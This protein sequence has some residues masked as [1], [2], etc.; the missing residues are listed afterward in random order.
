LTALALSAANNHAECVRL[1]LDAGANVN[2][3]MGE[4]STALM[5]AAAAAGDN[6]D[7]VKMLLA[8]GA[9]SSV[10]NVD[11]LTALDVAASTGNARIVEALLAH[12]VD[13]DDDECIGK[14]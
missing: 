6:D 3:K 11:G 7:C 12:Q 5:A 14:L 2:R 8:S 4:K 10:S 1:L 13:G 9:D